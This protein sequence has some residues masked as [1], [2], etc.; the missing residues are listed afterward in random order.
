MAEKS[1]YTKRPDGRKFEEL[2]KMTAKV[3]VV[4]EADGS[5]MFSFGE[6][7]EA[8]TAFAAVYGPRT[9]HPQ[10]MQN[11]RTGILRVNYDMLS[12]SVNERA[13]PGPNK[14]SKEISEVSK[15]ALGNVLELKDFPNTVID[16]FISI[17]QANASTR[18]AG[19]NAASMA[20]AHAGVPMKE[21]VGSVS[22]G[23]MD[24]T[25]VVDVN[26]KEEDYEEGEGP[27]DIAMAFTSR[28]QNVSLMQL[29]G[30]I[31][32]KELKEAVEMGQKAAM[33]II[34]VQTKA[35]KDVRG[36]VKK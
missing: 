33:E 10:H 12:F 28:G 24:R 29:D 17:T 5:A 19:I 35:L 14:R 15:W 32:P 23:K 25:L 36:D 7:K 26:K 31:R 1:K 4:K 3:G 27:T 16:V 34:K 13:R 22:I 18:C 30:K 8:T 6:G 21:L 9:L 11:P 2:R 20:L